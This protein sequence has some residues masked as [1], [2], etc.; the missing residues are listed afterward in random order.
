MPAAVRALRERKRRV[1]KPFAVMVSD[2]E[3]AEEFCEVDDDSATVVAQPQR[4]IV[5][6]RRREQAA[7]TDEVAPFNRYL[8]VFLPYT[9]LHHLLLA[10]GGFRRW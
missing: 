1:E 10:G 8:G 2:L 7:I 6:L 9:P 4:P 3:A 5:L